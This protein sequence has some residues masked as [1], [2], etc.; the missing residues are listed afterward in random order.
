MFGNYLVATHVKMVKL[1]VL[2]QTVAKHISA[3]DPF[4]SHVL[5]TI[6]LR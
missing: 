3:H 4:C 6:W 2:T 1:E 5:V